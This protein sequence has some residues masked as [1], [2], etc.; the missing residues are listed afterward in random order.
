LF[1]PPAKPP[2]LPPE[3]QQ[4]M[5]RLLARMLNEHLLYRPSPT[6]V[7]VGDE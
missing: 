3:V 2:E 1:S 6:R 5:T 4:R 7:E